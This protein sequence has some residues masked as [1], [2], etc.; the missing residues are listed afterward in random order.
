M[1]DHRYDLLA[2]QLA[3]HSLQIKT[4][5]KVLIDVTDTPD[6]MTA[7]LIKAVRGHG[8]LPFLRLNHSRLSGEMLS[9]AT[10]EQYEAI[11]RHAMAEMK[12]MDCYI[13][14][15]GKQNSFELSSVP[16]DSMATAM[17]HLRPVAQRRINKTRWCALDWP[18]PGMAQQ[19]GMSTP[20]FEDFYFNACLADYGKLGEAMKHLARLMESADQVR[21]TGP[22]TD[23]VFSIAGM[24]AIP[25]AGER[26]IPDGEVFTAPVRDSVEGS[27]LY[28]A[29]TVF[30]GIPFDNIAFEIEKGRISRASAG[31]PAKTDAL[32]R[33]L[34]TD[35]GAR[36]F[37]EFS[38]GTNP[39]ITFPMRNILFDEKIAG[40]FHLT[41]GQ[42][43]DVADNGNT[44]QVHW[45][46]VCIQTPEYGGG[47]IYLDGELFRDDGSFLDPKLAPLNPTRP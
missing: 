39:H 20:A 43:Y 22:G 29:P 33:I 23:L 44:S 1:T 14:I 27:I 28:T 26:N 16:S 3:V 12:D 5:D 17:K 2:R 30:Q 47:D 6:E 24:P 31:S 8:G 4:G 25:C 40:S 7:A 38:F 36:Y 18:T 35:P 42:A 45:D 46:L 15:R 41:P 19:A 21:I 9:G 10:D 11:A 37:G 34:D 13:A 32:N